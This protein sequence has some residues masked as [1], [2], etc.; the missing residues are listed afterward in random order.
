M[1]KKTAIKVIERALKPTLQRLAFGA[2]LYNAGVRDLFCA[3]DY[4]ERE[5]ILKALATLADNG[6]AIQ[7]LLPG[8][9]PSQSVEF[10]GNEI[11][12]SGTFES[13]R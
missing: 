4:K 9:A 7:L 12:S 11:N 5:R 6:Q 10:M 3:R 8:V 2:N 13:T 1:K